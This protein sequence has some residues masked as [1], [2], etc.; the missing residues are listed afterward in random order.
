MPARAISLPLALALLASCA[1]GGATAVIPLS[2][3]P[4]DPPDPEFVSTGEVQLGERSAAFDDWRVVGPNV[5]MVRRPDGSWAGSIFRQDVSL[6]AGEGSLL[7]ADAS[8]HF[9][10]WGGEVIV[11]GT[12]AGRKVQARLIPG[13]GVLTRAGILCR[14]DVNVVDCRT[15]S[16]DFTHGVELRGRAARTSDP[17]M[18]QLGLALLA[19]LY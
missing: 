17:L 11:R 18:P 5:N 4:A 19:A 13:E 9:V 12:I 6:S 15:A 16:H 3:V 1:T 14:L 8:L 2:P 10:R 7:G